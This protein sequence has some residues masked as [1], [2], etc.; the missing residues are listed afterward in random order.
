MEMAMT[1]FARGVPAL[2]RAVSASHMETAG[3][4]RYQPAE[5]GRAGDRLAITASSAERRAIRAE[6]AWIEAAAAASLRLP[7]G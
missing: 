5:L 7:R 2:K 6:H 4:G 1:T 3:A